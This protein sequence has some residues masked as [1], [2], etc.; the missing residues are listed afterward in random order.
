MSATEDTR[1]LL[2]Q[3]QDAEN[4]RNRV[5]AQL[6]EREAQFGRLQLDVGEAKT[7]EAWQPEVKKVLEALQISEHERAVGTFEKL[8]TALLNDILPGR[9][10]VLLDLSTINGTS[11]LDISLI[12]DDHIPDNF[13]DLDVP[14][15]QELALEDALTGAGGA[16]ANVL[17]MGL[18]MITLIRSGNR[19]FLVLDEAD[20][21]IKPTLVSAFAK[22]VQDAA[23]QLGIQVL[24]ISHHD[25]SHFPDINH[26]LHIRKTE[27]GL[28]ADWAVEGERPVWEED[29]AGFRAIALSGFQAHQT[30]YLPLSPGVT[31]I[32]GENDVGKSS[33][34]TALRAVF[35]GETSD[36]LIRHGEAA[37]KVVVEMEEGKVL[38]WE[39]HRKAGKDRH[40]GLYTLRQVGA[41]APLHETIKAKG[42]PDWL[43]SETGM[44]LI[45]ELDVQIGSQKD[46]VF[47]LNRPAP[48]RARA[49]AVGTDS[50]YVQ[51]MMNLSKEELS[52]AKALIKAGERQLEILHRQIQART[53]VRDI[54]T[55]PLFDTARTLSD[56]AE[57]TERLATLSS[58]W[59]EVRAHEVRLA[60]V[61]TLE[62]PTL[63]TLS[64]THMW[65]GLEKTWTTNHRLAG[66]LDRLPAFSPELPEMTSQPAWSALLETWTGADRKVNGL[67]D[68]PAFDGRVPDLQSNPSWAPLAETW[69][70]ALHQT[71]V[72][73]GLPAFEPALPT[74]RS[75]AG[76]EALLSEWKTA[77]ARQ[78]ALSAVADLAPVV[79][80][81]DLGRGMALQTLLG[82]WESDLHHL[83]DLESTLAQNEAELE[84]ARNELEALTPDICPTCHQAWPHSHSTIEHS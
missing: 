33:I 74:L 72:F 17:S 39:R 75:K 70:K 69:K 82:K 64:P 79:T 3:L 20:C 10:Q 63:P 29:Q 80:M 34:V 27:Q 1:R 22:V 67:A 61:A 36:A 62:L 54:L 83:Q 48:Q 78:T 45:E 14:A 16:V 71:E 9:R 18:R 5:M 52:E 7:R 73:S 60:P 26:R 42:T 4:R 38:T 77:M 28:R 12:K 84:M 25:E 47:L 41:T 6:E 31:L 40:K 55:A 57:K 15:R 66:L 24:M 2:G 59:N 43:N 53:G 13:A 32:Y 19:R 68:L 37:A 81:P 65:V 23:S 30:T 51:T 76:W 49:L 8:L 56:K 50:G 21:W 46:P 44:G 11:A 35:Y 58:T